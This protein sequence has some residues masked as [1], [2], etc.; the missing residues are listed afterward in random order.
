MSE[1]AAIEFRN[2]SKN[3]VR[4][5]KGALLRSHL[6]HWLGTPASVFHAL[7]NI[8]FKLQSGDSLAVVGANGAGKSTLLSLAAGIANPESGEIVVHGRR[9]ALLELGSG[10][11]SDLTGAENILL[12]AAL[13]GFK[14]S[15]ARAVMP[16]IVDFCELGDFLEEPLRTYSSGMI[17]RLAFAVAVHVNPDILITDEVLAVGDQAFQTKCYEK[18]YEMRR[19]GTTMLCASHSEGMLRSLCTKAIWLDHGSLILEGSLDEVFGAYQGS[20]DARVSR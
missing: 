11:H 19:A 17:M 7:R 1:S 15:E 9:A 20:I 18:I 12:N 14:R 4:H 3:F 10:F 13:L 8:S 6:V 16:R 2:V 5:G